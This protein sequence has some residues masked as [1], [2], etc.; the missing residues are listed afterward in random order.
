MRDVPAHGRGLGLEGLS[1]SLP[2]QTIL[3]FSDC[4]VLW[5]YDRPGQARQGALLLC[6]PGP[7]CPTQPLPGPGTRG[8]PLPPGMVISISTGTGIKHRHR[9]WASPLLLHCFSIASPQGI[10]AGTRKPS[11]RVRSLSST[12]TGDNDVEV[13]ETFRL[14]PWVPDLCW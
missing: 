4:R 12:Q 1:R 2:T 9:H 6:S 3:W 11:H 10:S 13:T 14:S 7:P 8:G 5:F